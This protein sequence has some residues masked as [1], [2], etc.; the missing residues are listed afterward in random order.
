V[1]GGKDAAARGR[2]GL[3]SGR[4]AEQG[5]QRDRRPVE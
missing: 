3:Q 2:L 1:N 5:S 4:R